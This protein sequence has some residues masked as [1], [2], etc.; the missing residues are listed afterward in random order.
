[1]ETLSINRYYI[2]IT[3]VVVVVVVVV[4]EGTYSRKECIRCF[5]IHFKRSSSSECN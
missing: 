4:E 3:V 2:I 1:M 5:N